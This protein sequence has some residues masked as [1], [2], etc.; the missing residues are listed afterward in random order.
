M[1][2]REFSYVLQNLETDE[3]FANS[4]SVQFESMEEEWTKI[5]DLVFTTHGVEKGWFIDSDGNEISVDELSSHEH[6][7]FIQND[8]L[9]L[10]VNYGNLYY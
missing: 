7:D 6:W 9:V 3:V 10:E 5:E 8:D 4:G 2:L 1:Y